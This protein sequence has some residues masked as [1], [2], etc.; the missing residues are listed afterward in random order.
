[1]RHRVANSVQVGYTTEPRILLYLCPS[2]VLV[3]DRSRVCAVPR[4]MTTSARTAV[5]VFIK[6][7]SPPTEYDLSL[8]AAHLHLNKP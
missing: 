1:M 4:T 8:P 6:H 3:D 2:E 5:P 7:L